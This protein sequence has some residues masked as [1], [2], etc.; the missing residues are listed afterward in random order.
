MVISKPMEVMEG[1][2]LIV[3]CKFWICFG[4]VAFQCELS[5]HSVLLLIH[6]LCSSLG[7]GGGGSGGAVSFSACTLTAGSS[8]KIEAKGGNGGKARIYGKRHYVSYLLSLLDESLILIQ[9]YK[10]MT[11]LLTQDMA[12][13]EGLE[14]SLPTRQLLSIMMTV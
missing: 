7:G 8:A 4:L 14:E 1:G 10:Q 13:V 2:E 12:V 11:L 6:I 9:S 5:P 3:G